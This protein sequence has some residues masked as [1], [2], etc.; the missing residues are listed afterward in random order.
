[1]TVV[2]GAAALSRE[3]RSLGELARAARSLVLRPAA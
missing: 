1:M 2:L 3:G